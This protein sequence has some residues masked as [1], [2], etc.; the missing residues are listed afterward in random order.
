MQLLFQDFTIYE[1]NDEAHY[2]SNSESK[3]PEMIEK[4]ITSISASLP[5][6]I[7]N[8]KKLRSSPLQVVERA[9]R[10]HVT[11]FIVS[12]T[13]TRSLLLHNNSHFHLTFA[14][15]RKIIIKSESSFLVVVIIT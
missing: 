12:V 5:K 6:N 8:R 15:R 7:K 9:M 11:V 2:T 1:R 13:S 4:K 14:I 10:D 3:N